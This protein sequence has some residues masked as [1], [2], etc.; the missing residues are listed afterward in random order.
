MA[1]KEKTS[2]WNMRMPDNLKAHLAKEAKAERRDLTG[3][4]IYL[5]ETHPA[6]AKC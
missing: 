6:R 4:I 5:L 2:Q 3:H 1:K